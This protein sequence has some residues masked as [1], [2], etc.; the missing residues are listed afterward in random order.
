MLRFI[1]IYSLAFMMV[2]VINTNINAGAEANT[3]VNFYGHLLHMTYDYGFT[4]L[5]LKRL[6]QQELSNQANAFRNSGLE[7]AAVSISQHAKTYVLDDMGINLFIDKFIQQQFNPDKGNEKT[8]IKYLLLKE[9]GY[10]V[11]LTR[12]GTQLNCMGNLSFTPGRYI[13]ITYNNKVY[14]DLDFNKRQQSGKHFIFMDRVKT[15]ASLSRNILNLP[16]IHAKKK[17]KVL[18][19]KYNGLEYM[20]NAQANQSVIEFLEDLPMYKIGR[21]YTRLGVS[22]ELDNSLMS[23]LR[24]QTRTMNKVEK[25]QFL[26][27]FVQQAI[28]YGSDY[29]KYGEERYYYPEQTVTASTADC[30]DKTFLYSYL[31][32]RVA[33]LQTVALYFEH[34]EHLSIGIEI[35]DYSDAYSFKYD[36]KY[37][38]SCEPTAQS[39]KLGYSAFDLN[40]VTKVT[41]L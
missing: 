19:F 15:Y 30:E 24:E 1:R 36:G 28:P 8:F 27:S 2:F 5:Q 21:E 10:D 13:Y 33:G 9:L 3:K 32:R 18:E 25:A 40:R 16:K 17:T 29:T 38:I 14:K 26:L 37:Y 20:V 31:L 12:T 4:T 23:Y 22:T 35:P 6:D 11:I 41:R 39:P 34:D 7:N